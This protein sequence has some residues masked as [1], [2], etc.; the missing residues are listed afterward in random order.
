MSFLEILYL[1]QSYYTLIKEGLYFYHEQIQYSMK[2]ISKF[3]ALFLSLLVV[4]SSF[5]QAPPSIVAD[6]FQS[7]LEHSLPTTFSHPGAII[8]VYVP[9]KW[10]WSSA[11]GYAISGTTVGQTQ[12]IAN[13]TD[14]F[15]V[16]SIT[17]MML[18]TCILKLQEQ[19]ELSIEDPISMHLRASLVNDTIASSE[20][21]KIKHL[22]NHTS[23]IANSGDNNDCQMDVLGNPTGAHTLEE[24]IFCGAS[25]GEIFPPEFA[26]A[27]SNTNYSILAMIIEKVSGLSWKDFLTQTIITPLQLSNT[28]I[29]VTNQINGSHMGCYWNI[30]SWIDLTIINPTTYAGW[31]DVVS[32]TSDLITFM[33]ALRSGEIINTNSLLLMETEFPGTY[34][35]GLG[36]DLYTY[37]GVSYNGHFGEV[38]NLSGLFFANTTSERA[39]NG[40]YISYNYNVQ[41]AD[42]INKLGKPIFAFLNS[43][44]TL[45]VISLHTSKSLSKI[46]PNPACSEFTIQTSLNSNEELKVVLIDALGKIVTQNSYSGLSNF[47]VDCS[48]IKRGIYTVSIQSESKIEYHQV[49]LN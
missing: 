9:G 45:D 27:Y 23:G 1:N 37:S 20:T 8:Q 19:G 39:P 46:F 24:A 5:A 16:G 38:A 13:A 14:K 41:G 29:P 6:S 28:E 11:A 18:A 26:W 42:D 2:T 21:V 48:Q 7:I 32:T 4:E 10:S 30:G 17:K 36:Y 12:T 43:N 35:Y 25:Q 40:Y 44:E 47:P 31:A 3:C 33:T 22:L 15:R 49:I 34:D